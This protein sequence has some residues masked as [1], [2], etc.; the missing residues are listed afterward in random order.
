VTP[1]AEALRAAVDGKAKPVGALGR[2]ED[3]ALQI[4]LITGS[5][6]PDLGRAALIVFAGD[7]GLTAEGV[8][9][10]PPEVTA[11]VAQMVLDG[12]AGANIAAK[13]AGSDVFL[14]DA[15]LLGAP[16]PHPTLISRRMGAGTANSAREPAMPQAAAL[17]ALDAGAAI[18]TDFAGQGYGIFALG[19]IGIGNSSAAAL[20]A[21]AVTGIPLETLTGPGAGAPP[22]GISHKL[23]VLKGVAARARLSEQQGERGGHSA[24][25]VAVLE[26]P[27]TQSAVSALAEVAGF[28][29]AMLAGA[30]I[31][32]ARARKLVLIDGFI[33]TACA[34]AAVQIAPDTWAN[35][36]FAHRSAEPGHGALLAH[37]GATPLLD[38]GMRLGEGTGAA[39]AI[40]LVRM[41]EGLL[42]DMADLPGAHPA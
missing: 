20:L 27:G 34:A 38:L 1:L 30:I 10:Y 22:G 14:V 17:G 32:A 40:P 25:E 7:H 24:G 3:L 15:G 16:A 26:A 42:R 41:A 13:A 12:R 28:E 29:M 5:S 31:G 11:L 6:K 18:A 21:H 39:L 33:A 35:C 9:A 2:I 36:V 4:G 23:K 8:T 19:E 37:L